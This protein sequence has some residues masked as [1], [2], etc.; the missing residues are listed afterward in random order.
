MAK[1]LIPHEGAKY[2]KGSFLRMSSDA[3]L[4][5]HTIS[6][7]RGGKVSIVKPEE[8]PLVGVYSGT[9]KA[10]VIAPAELD[11]KIL[12]NLNVVAKIPGHKVSYLYTERELENVSVPLFGNQAIM[13]FKTGE[14][15]QLKGEIEHF[16]KE[17]QITGLHAE[18]VVKHLTK[19]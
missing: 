5:T 1:R 12:N 11:E 2:E 18:A 14:E 6:V 10:H 4:N 17:H 16:L 8:G 9:V 3:K 19:S 7:M 13:H 15:S